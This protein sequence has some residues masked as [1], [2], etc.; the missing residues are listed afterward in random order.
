[1]SLSK[2][3]LIGIAGGTEAENLLLQKFYAMILL[4]QI[5]SELLKKT[6]T[7]KIKQI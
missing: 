3:I 5:Q 4:I 7:I 1:M 2:P 6:I